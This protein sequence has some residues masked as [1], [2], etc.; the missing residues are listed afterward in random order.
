MLLVLLGCAAPSQPDPNAFDWMALGRASPCWATWVCT[1]CE[2]PTA[3]YL[4]SW[5]WLH[6]RCPP[7][8]SW[9]L[10]VVIIVWLV[11]P[12]ILVFCFFPMVSPT[13]NAINP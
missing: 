2:T 8:L 5:C 3:A 4:H 10:A 9:L 1:W 11:L 7:P 12:V 6:R 13:D